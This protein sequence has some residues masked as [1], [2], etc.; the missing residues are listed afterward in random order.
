MNEAS[1]LVFTLE[2]VAGPANFNWRVEQG[3]E[4][5]E[6]SVDLAGGS[7][8]STML[9][10]ENPRGTIH[11]ALAGGGLE[12][13]VTVASLELV[14][15]AGVTGVR[16][17]TILVAQGVSMAAHNLALGL[18][19]DPKG[20]SEDVFPP[21]FTLSRIDL[22]GARSTGTFTWQAMRT[23]D[24][25]QV[26]LGHS[27]FD[28]Q[29]VTARPGGSAP[30]RVEFPGFPPK[31]VPPGGVHGMLS[32]ASLPSQRD[33]VRMSGELRAGAGET[34]VRGRFRGPVVLVPPPAIP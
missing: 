30:I 26:M 5:L 28:G 1:P 9:S 12:G 33:L 34:A 18:F 27:L 32:V 3:E 23:G 16:L 10:A 7:P 19:S 6:V 24:S 25:F 15:F 20:G 4:E 8:L 21:P 22:Q 31:K 13:Q 29:A 2:T 14:T 17:D 11:G